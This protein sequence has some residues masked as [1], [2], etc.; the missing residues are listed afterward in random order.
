MKFSVKLSLEDK[1]GKKT[2]QKAAYNVST[3]PVLV[4]KRGE[5]G[6]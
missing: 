6:R 4:I 3:A 2:E 5:E 1:S